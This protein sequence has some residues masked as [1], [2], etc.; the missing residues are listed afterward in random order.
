MLQY[1]VTVLFSQMHVGRAVSVEVHFD[2]SVA[3]DISVPHL[4]AAIGG[5]GG[6]AASHASGCPAGG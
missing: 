5:V 2:P 1:A 4:F 6:A 3:A